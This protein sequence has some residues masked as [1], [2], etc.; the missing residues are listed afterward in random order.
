MIKPVGKYLL[1]QKKPKPQNKIILSIE[2]NDEPFEV[3]LLGKG[4]KSETEAEVGDLLLLAPYSG[5]MFDKNDEDHL[6]ILDQ[7]ILGIVNG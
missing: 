2:N 7:D 5:K 4:N 3:T 6:L 1:V